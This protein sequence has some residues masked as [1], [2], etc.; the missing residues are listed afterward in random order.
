[1]CQNTTHAPE[2]TLVFITLQRHHSRQPSFITASMHALRRKHLSRRAAQ[3]QAFR[4]HQRQYV[5]HL[6]ATRRCCTSPLPPPLCREVADPPPDT[7]RSLSRPL[8]C[9]CLVFREEGG[10]RG[11]GLKRLIQRIKTQIF[12]MSLSLRNEKNAC[13]V[14][15]YAFFC[16]KVELR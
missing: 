10:K 2:Q 14:P 8:D 12:L 3:R 16:Q 7:L 4:A 1:M 13:L 15:G 5:R 6:H 9:V 11:P